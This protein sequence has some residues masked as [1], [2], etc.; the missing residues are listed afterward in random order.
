[1]DF[2]SIYFLPPKK[3]KFTVIRQI[4]WLVASGLSRAFP[5][6][7]LQWHLAGDFKDYSQQRAGCTGFS[8]VSLL[9]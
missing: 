5:E 2:K 9:S 1:L 4:F 8:P 7:L 3:S 6:E